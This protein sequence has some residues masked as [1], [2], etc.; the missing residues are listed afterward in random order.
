MNAKSMKPALVAAALIAAATLACRLLSPTAAPTPA[1]PAPVAAGDTPPPVAAGDNAALF[2]DDF[3]DST[4]WELD[5]DSD[6][7]IDYA[8]DAI[9]IKLWSGEYF[10]WTN[11]LGRTFKNVHIEVT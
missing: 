7:V 6:Y 11:L 8:E 1:A 5:A 10:G 3:K 9:R 2:Q 4:N